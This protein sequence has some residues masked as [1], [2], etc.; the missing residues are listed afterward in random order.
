MRPLLQWSLSLRAQSA[1]QVWGQK[2]CNAHQD[3][4]DMR[5]RAA[6]HLPNVLLECRLPV[7]GV[8]AVATAANEVKCVTMENA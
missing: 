2:G 3:L 4:L 1:L 7:L 6:K 8:R 5:N